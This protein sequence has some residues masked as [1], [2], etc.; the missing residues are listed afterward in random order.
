MISK[1]KTLPFS[2]VSLVAGVAPEA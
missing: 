1:E 2:V